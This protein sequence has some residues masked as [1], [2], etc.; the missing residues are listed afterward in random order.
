MRRSSGPSDRG[1]GLRERHGERCR[2]PFAGSMRCDRRRQRF[3][4]CVA[5]GVD[6]DE[7][8]FCAGAPA[9]VEPASGFVGLASACGSGGSIHT[10]RIRRVRL[11][12][13][14]GLQCCDISLEGVHALFRDA[15]DGTG[16][17]PRKLFSTEM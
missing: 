13:Y 3:A 2:G 5:R 7:F 16:I 9:R 12:F 4:A 11:F 17:L 10:R 15:A 14:V 1:N 6:A 8:R